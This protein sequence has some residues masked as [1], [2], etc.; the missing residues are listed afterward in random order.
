ME[1]CVFCR[2]MAWAFAWTEQAE[3]VCV[4]CAHQWANDEMASCTLLTSKPKEAA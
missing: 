3:P 2:I 1:R 4:T